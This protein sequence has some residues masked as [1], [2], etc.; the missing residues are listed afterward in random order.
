MSLLAALYFWVHNFT[1][2]H[3]FWKNIEADSMLYLLKIR[4]NFPKKI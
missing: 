1:L 3:N 4:Q 2:L